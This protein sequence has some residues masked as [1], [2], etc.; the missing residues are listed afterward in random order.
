MASPADIPAPAAAEDLEAPVRAP[1]RAGASTYGQ[2]LKSSV[3]IGSS[4]VFTI[5]T[6]LVRSKVV[7]LLLGPSGFG[8]MGL[9]ASIVQVTQ[10]VAGM[11]VNSSGVREIAAAAGTGEAEKVARTAAVLRRT[12]LVLGL[13]GATL[14]AV[15]A[16][17]IAELTFGSGE[18]AG[19]VALL[20]LTVFFG[21]VNGGHAALVQGLR[22][23][24]DLARM[25]ALGSLSGAVATV[26]L[27]SL[28]R[29]RGIVAALIATAAASVG[30]S[31]WY[32]RKLDRSRPRLS[33]GEV[34]REATGLLKLGFAFMASGMLMTGAAYAIRIF[35]VRYAGVPAAGLYQSAW[36]LGGLYVGFI[37]EAMGSDFYPRLTS[38]IRDHD[39]ANRLVNEQA[40]VSLL[41][42]GPGLLATLVLA[43]A[44]LT[45]LY[46]RAFHG[47]VPILRWM[48]LGATMQV[49]TW[50]LG[51]IIVAQAR[52][53]L[54]FWV[55]CAY[56]AV[57]VALSWVLVRWLG[58]EGAGV[59]FFGSYVFHALLVYPI[60][61]R[62]TG[63]RWSPVNRRAVLVYLGSIASVFV[64]SELLPPWIA[65]AFGC[66]VLVANAAYSLRD[67]VRLV[68]A[69]RVPP[70]L[71][72]VLARVRPRSGA[73]R[74]QE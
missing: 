50:P 40:H 55:E 37:L 27:V 71:S 5:G 24:A 11:G 21:A 61:R 19:A 15:L 26:V 68:P 52:Q 46:S 10:S 44:V 63:F 39:D 72:R 57:Y 66:V 35:V 73:G 43:P 20:S 53:S 16:R 45:V 13:L 3:L 38:A 70:R 7:A 59:A 30:F 36:A 42:A 74:G 51:Y 4:R 41:L 47:A 62:L 18:H 1:A 12:S 22:R 31:W 60:V 28:F 56:A 65:T 25:T 32:S 9:Y 23:I 58:L 69:D 29:E 64:A 48:T 54:F 2:I 67:L 17:P 49:I 8:L 33:A 34:R 6:G 14:L